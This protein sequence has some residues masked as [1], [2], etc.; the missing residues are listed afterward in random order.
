MPQALDEEP[1]SSC[2]GISLP[3]VDATILA[4]VIEYCNKHVAA[5]GTMDNDS[6]DVLESFEREFIRVSM[7]TIL[8]LIVATDNL[9]VTGLVD[10]PCA[11]RRSR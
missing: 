3:G 10:L 8:E 2:E 6:D 4:K 11:R 5:A 1:K 9:E 7:S